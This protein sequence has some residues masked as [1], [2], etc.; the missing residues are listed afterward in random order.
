MSEAIWGVTSGLK[1]M[2]DDT[3]RITIDINPRYFTEACNQF[4]KRGIEVA[5]A[6]LVQGSTVE[7]E[8]K[9]PIDQIK[10]MNQHL[11]DQE[12][13]GVV[14][15]SNGSVQRVKGGELS[16]L[17]AR[18]CQSQEFQEYFSRLTGWDID[19]EERCT[20]AIKSYLAIES[21]AEID[22]NETVKQMFHKIRKEYVQYQ[23][24]VRM[25]Q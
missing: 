18:F 14:V 8:R 15:R 24:T 11:V 1:T 6:R 2:A 25:A 13:D 3:V 21:R 23:E 22:H 5:L 7:Y 10:E 4:G 9:D 17:C 20:Q 12:I 19:S 16:K